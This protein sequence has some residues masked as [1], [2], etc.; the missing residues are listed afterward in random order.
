MDDHSLIRE[1]DVHQTIQLTRAFSEEKK[2][3]IMIETG[4]IQ[5]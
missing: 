5:L 3:F 4:T 2:N 1:K